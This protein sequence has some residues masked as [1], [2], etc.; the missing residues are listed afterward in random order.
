MTIDV[1]DESRESG[2]PKRDD[3]LTFKV[4][5]RLLTLET[6]EEE[7]HVIKSFLNADKPLNAAVACRICEK[8]GTHLIKMVSPRTDGDQAV[9]FIKPVEANSNPAILPSVNGPDIPFAKVIFRPLEIM[10]HKTMTLVDHVM[11]PIDISQD[12]LASFGRVFGADVVDVIK[13]ALGNPPPVTSLGSGEFPIVFIPSPQGG[14]IQVTP[15]A[16]ATAYMGM[17]DAMAPYFQKQTDDGPKVPRGKFHSQVVSSKMQNISGA[18]GGSR[19]RLLAVMPTVLSASDAEIHRFVRGGSFPRWR[20]PD[21]ADWVMKYGD[22]LDRHKTYNN[23]DTRAGLDGFA[24]RL[25]RDAEAF[26]SETMLDAAAIA[27]EGVTVPAVPR[28]DQVL[29]RRRWKNNTFDRARRVLSS[30]HFRNR[31]SKAGRAN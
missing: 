21:V 15:L 14:D 23:S 11:N 3:I 5:G 28:V 26:I 27:E 4:P 7:F 2:A 10:G 25:V 30:E 16:P 12:V 13:D 1:V 20:D 24:D 9:L 22:L 17:K 29:L 6:V 18:I 19:H 31:I 8:S